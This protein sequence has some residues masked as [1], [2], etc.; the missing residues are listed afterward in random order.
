MKDGRRLEPAR[1]YEVGYGRPPVHTRFRKGQSGNP[2]GRPRGSPGERA[3]RIVLEEAYRAVTVKEGDN[4]VRMPA[5]RA[6]M[7]SHLR[8]ALKG[9]GPNQRAVIGL[10]RARGRRSYHPQSCCYDQL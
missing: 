4:V 10:I 9:N 6:V 7:R 3:K 8:D 2:R 5:I 1:T